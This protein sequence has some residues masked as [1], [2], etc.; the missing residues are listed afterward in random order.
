MTTTTTSSRRQAVLEAVVA[1]LQAIEVA[2]G[3]ATDAG[4]TVFLGEAPALGPDDPPV[5]IAVVARD[6]Q[7]APNRFE[8]LPIEIQAI[9][10]ADLN[11]P[12]MA[13]ETVFSDVA[14]AM[15]LTDRT[16]G[17]LVKDIEIGPTRLLPRD[18]GSTAVGTSI[19]YE[20]SYV[21]VWGTP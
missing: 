3:Y 17:G 7:P 2:N 21:R 1:R 12:Y 13:A 10:K 6:T 18:D 4:Q 8:V 9:A 16:L 11:Q 15:E 5:A 19:V 20:L 14:R